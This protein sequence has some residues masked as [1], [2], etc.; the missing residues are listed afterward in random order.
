MTKKDWGKVVMGNLV[1]AQLLFFKDGVVVIDEVV[2]ILD[3]AFSII[4]TY[5][6]RERDYFEDV[7]RRINSELCLAGY[8]SEVITKFH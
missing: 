1:H 8:P 3:T 4:T 6:L 2:N 5:K 7:I